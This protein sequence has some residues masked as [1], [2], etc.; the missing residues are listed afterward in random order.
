MAI[1]GQ[2]R[3]R[4]IFLIFVI[5]MALFA[6]VI[7]G[8]FD[9]NNNGGAPTDPIGV[10]NE[11]D[12]EVE[13]FRQLVEQTERSYNFTTLQAV[14]AVWEQSLRGLILEQQFKSLGIDA[15]RDQIEQILS[16]NEA[17]INDPR[18]QNEAGFFDFGRFTDF[19]AQM[20]AENPVAYDQ[21]KYQEASIISMAKEN[22]YLDLI[23]SSSGFTEQEGKATYH[24]ENDKVNLE[25][26]KIP[27]DVVP[28]SLIKVTD[29]DIKKYI[30][31]HQ[32][33][34]KKE[35]Y[36]HI[37]YVYFG[38]EASPEDEAYLYDELEAL[39][40]TKIEYND[41]SKLT[42]TLEGFKTTK[43]LSEFIDRYSDQPFDSLYKTKGNLPGEFAEVI[44]ALNEGETFGPYKD[45]NT[46]KISKLIGRKKDASIRA[47]HIL[48]AYQGAARANASVTRTKAEA[49]RL[50]NSLY[51]QVRRSPD[52]FA[53]VAMANSDGPTRS[54]G[55]DLG[56]FQ[57]GVM[58]QK[59]FDFAT[60]NRIGRIG[61]VET[62][63]GFHV[64]KVEDKQDLVLLAEVVKEIVPSDET[65]NIIFKEATQFE[66]DSKNAN[67]FVATA[68]KNNYNLVPVRN[69]NVM[70]EFL[71]GGIG[72]QRAIV[73]WAFDSETDLG[74]IRK[75][76]LSSGGYAVVQLSKVAQE[77]IE[78]VAEARDAVTPIIEK[79]KKAAW[80]KKEYAA[81][82]TV[83]E[84]SEKIDEEIETASAVT[85]KN[86]TLVG[87]GKEPY[88]IGAAFALEVNE[89]SSLLEGNNGVY[90]V[91]LT[92]KEIAEDLPSYT[93]YANAL[94]T[95]EYNRLSSSI[96]EALKSA[97]E[98]TDNRPLYY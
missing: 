72:R 14:N 25:Y 89:T 71:P 83:Q 55:G 31:D 4:S 5:G 76:S 3:Q 38:E 78:S 52:T 61:V 77:G 21:W 70:D 79:Q 84:L 81:F 57:E 91:H 85:Q 32:E 48:I 30:A 1:L 36:R 94:R 37:Q 44:F 18:F 2:I 22:I 28:D 63:F 67:D 34:F 46:Y 74:D 19:I 82:K 23:R 27:F 87:A 11:Q 50:A 56:F 43:N 75:F 35:A 80:I 47:S 15:G 7:S 20:K 60:S 17:F 9:G 8:V 98:I 10:V 12:I 59:F 6:F 66:I 26:V 65:S 45:G 93:A 96:F 29:Q 40:D 90:L 73:Q 88:I 33:D 49:E 54:L 58:D 69:L 42:D 53:E 97:A 68:E 64:I 16:S 13:F 86:A 51:R 92:A 24:L 95:E 41:V 62:D 39:L